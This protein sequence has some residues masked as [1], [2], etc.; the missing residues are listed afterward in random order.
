MTSDRQNASYNRLMDLIGSWRRL[1]SIKLDNGVERIGR[2]QSIGTEAY[3]HEIFPPLDN[4]RIDIIEDKLNIKLHQSL[5]DFF[6]LHNGLDLYRF[7][8]AVYGLRT[9]YNR[10]TE[11]VFLAQPFDLVSLNSLERPIKEKP[12]LMFLGTI[13]DD[14][15]EVTVFPDGSVARWEGMIGEKLIARFEDIFE[16]LVV[17]AE[18]AN[19]RV[20]AD[21][22][23]LRTG[24]EALH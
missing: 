14:R 17:E 24:A 4:S 15:Q 3:M 20:G 7:Q 13:G 21:G 16:F 12:E 6:L 19:R 22:L 8:I 2:L 1:G 18:S 23:P 5:R 11:N 9:T 10:T